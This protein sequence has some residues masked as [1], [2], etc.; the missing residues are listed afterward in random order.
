MQAQ[1]GRR[2]GPRCISDGQKHNEYFL[3]LCC[4][5]EQS[6]LMGVLRACPAK[7]VDGE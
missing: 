7:L 1:I 5:L 6:G 2:S 3:F 4:G